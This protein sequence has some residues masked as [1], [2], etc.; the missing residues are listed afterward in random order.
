L[1]FMTRAANRADYKKL[2]DADI[3]A[4]IKHLRSSG[5]EQ[6]GAPAKPVIEAFTTV[7]GRGKRLRGTLTMVGYEMCGGSNREMILQA[8]RAME[9]IHASLLIID[10]LQDRSELR[11]GLPTAHVALGEALAINAGLLGSYAAQMI[12]SNLDAP[13]ELRANTLSITNR[14]LITTVH[15]QSA[16]M[17]KNTPSETVA[18]WKTAQYSVLNPLHVGMVLAGAD[19]QATDVITP[20]ALELGLA[21]QIKNDIDGLFDADGQKDP[22]E[23]IRQGKRTLLSEY[24]RRHASAA[25]KK[26]LKTALGNAELTDRDFKKCLKIF[27]DCGALEHARNKLAKH[28]Q[29]ALKALR[30]CDYKWPGPGQ[31]LLAGLAG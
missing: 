6:F 20:Y 7:L 1:G 8:A 16:D 30:T 27:K 19:C 3:A 4:Y 24:A 22:A 28:Q 2:I 21:Y 31:E 29:S 11:H 9:M 14:T 5:Q 15:G 12:L 25:D 10:D 18:L 13:A 26:F 17:L 23:D